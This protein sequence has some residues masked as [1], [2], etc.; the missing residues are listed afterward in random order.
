MSALPGG[1]SRGAG[2]LLAVVTCTVGFLFVGWYG[3]L[4]KQ[5]ILQVADAVVICGAEHCPALHVCGPA[6]Q[7]V[8]EVALCPGRR[9][10]R[11]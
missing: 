4:C 7:E 8:Q 6:S 5:V 10:T 9:N 3:Q 11:A 1:G 2:I